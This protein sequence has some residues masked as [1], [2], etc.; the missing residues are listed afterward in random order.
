MLANLEQIHTRIL[1]LEEE[2]LVTRTLRRLDPERQQVV[3]TA[4]LDEAIEKAPTS[5]NVK[6]IAERAE[7]SV[8]SLYMYF[9][10]RE[11]LLS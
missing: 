4:I 9:H 6:K 5:I 3:L 11:N 7:V 8:G 2:G 10:N 1:E